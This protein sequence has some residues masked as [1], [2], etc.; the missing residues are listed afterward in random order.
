MSLPFEIE[1]R[2]EEIIA[3]VEKL[4]ADLLEIHFRSAAGRSVITLIVD[5]P[6]GVTLA[7]CVRINQRLSA[8]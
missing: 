5:K 1:N 7:D 2:R 3:E 6:G 8:D 4:G